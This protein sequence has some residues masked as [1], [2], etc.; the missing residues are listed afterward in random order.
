MKKIILIIMFFMWIP[1]ITPIS[2]YAEGS[3]Q[4]NQRQEWGTSA[5]KEEIQEY[6]NARMIFDVIKFFA[7]LGL[8]L[9]VLLSPAIIWLIVYLNVPE[10]STIKR[11]M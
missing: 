7:L 1:A 10:D 8:I 11:I 6:S 2:I 9:L 4:F 3:E 5:A